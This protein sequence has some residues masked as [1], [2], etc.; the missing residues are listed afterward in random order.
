[1]ARINEIDVEHV[2]VVKLNL[3]TVCE[4]DLQ[5]GNGIRINSVESFDKKNHNA[6]IEDGLQSSFFGTD[7]S[8]E[9]SFKERYRCKCGALMGKCYDGMICNICN[10]EVQ[11]HDIDLKKTGWIILNKYK[12]MSPIYQAKLADVLGKFEGDRVLDKIIEMDYKDGEEITYTDKEL[13]NIKKHPFT[14]KGAIWLSEHIDEVLDF[15]ERK[16]PSKAKAFRELRLEKDRMF[17]HCIPV[18]T[19]L[20]RTE[21]PGERGGKEYKL[22]IN[23][24]Y[25]ALIRTVNAINSLTEEIS[26]TDEFGINDLTINSIDI[27]LGSIYKEIDKIFE[28][29]YN[30]LT[31]KNGIITSK[32]LGGRYNFSARNIII[33]SAR[34][35]RLDSDEIEISYVAFMELYR[36]EIQNLY[37]K[38][39]DATPT[40]ANSAWKKAINHF[41]ERF[42]NVID[43]M[44]HDPEYKGKLGVLIN[45]NPSIN[46]GSFIYVHIVSVKRDFS[47][48]TL[49]ISTHVLTPLNADFDGDIMNIFRIIGEDMAKRFSKNLNPKYNLFVSRMDGLVNKECLPMKDSIVGFWAFNNI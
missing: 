14:K 9:T 34:S 11:Y 13:A 20:L 30:D 41:D 12:C 31:N 37:A 8:D 44:L 48:K 18:F 1:M 2:R 16:K 43:N 19:S 17:T 26:P 7:F 25:K 39:Y 3:D 6:K 27:L 32:V 24:C 38:M 15:Y 29:T 23:T 49:T 35:G 40:Q 10:T 22:K 46:Y 45:R 33:P 28:I 42:Y 36:Y 4:L 5:S 47:D 21:I